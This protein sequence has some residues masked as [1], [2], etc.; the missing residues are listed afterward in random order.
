MNHDGVRFVA[1]IKDAL[2]VFICVQKLIRVIGPRRPTPQRQTIRPTTHASFARRDIAR[3]QTE[4]ETRIAKTADFDLRVF[5]FQEHA[6]KVGF[7]G[8]RRRHARSNQAHC[9]QAD[10]T[11]A[12]KHLRLPCAALRVFERFMQ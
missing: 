5:T 12:F 6:R 10:N 7:Q 11:I 2:T 9:G 8:T 3:R 4:V 1:D